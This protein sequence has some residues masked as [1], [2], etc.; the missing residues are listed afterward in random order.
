MVAYACANMV[1]VYDCFESKKV[2]F[3]LGGHETRVNALEWLSE[4]EIIS[5][6]D[7][8]VV[9]KGSGVDGNNW[10]VS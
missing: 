8:I 10:T 3:S 2:H 5:V 7:R 4:D 1:L 6:S 9:H